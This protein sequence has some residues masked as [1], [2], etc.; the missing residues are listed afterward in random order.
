MTDRIYY[1]VTA[2]DRLDA[3]ELRAETRPA[4]LEYIARNRTRVALAGPLVNDE[5]QSCGSLYMIEAST[6]ADASE[7]VNSDPYSVA[8][9]FESVV[10]R[11]WRLVIDN[12]HG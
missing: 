12:I 3:G 10:I 8:G 9:L 1:A 7:F 2:I 6:E 4:H 11:R 5:G